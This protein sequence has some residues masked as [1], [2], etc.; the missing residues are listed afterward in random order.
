MLFRYLKSLAKITLIIYPEGTNTEAKSFVMNGRRMFVYTLAITLIIGLLGFYVIYLTPLERIFLPS[1]LEKK[2]LEEK[3]F[4]ELS[5]KIIYLTRELENLKTANSKLRNAVQL[6]DSTL[7]RK[8]DSGGEKNNSGNKIPTE[9]NLLAVVHKL[10]NS[11]IKP[12]A[13]NEDIFFILPVNGY[14]SREFKPQQGHFGVDFVVRENTPVYAAAGGYVIFAN[15]TTQYGFTVL[16]DHGS[17]YISRYM[18]CNQIVKRE[19]EIV[20]QGELIALSGNSGTD[21]T[22]PH[23]HFEIWKN[24]QPIDPKKVLLNY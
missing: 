8:N 21:T 11:Y 15:Y 4:E 9:G 16:I 2:T 12:D 23:L 22:G 7:I 19:G 10:F 6:G 20:K 13:N 14:M 24:G 17:G 18:H 1:W 3:Q 5:G